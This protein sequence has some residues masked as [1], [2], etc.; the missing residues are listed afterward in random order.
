[1]PRQ[2]PVDWDDLGTALTT[3]PAE[4]SCYLDTRTG[5]VLMVPVDRLDGEDDWPSD[6]EIDAGLDAGHLIAIEP[7]GASVEYGWM[8]EF[9]SRPSAGARVVAVQSLRGQDGRPVNS[10]RAT[11]APGPRLPA[12]ATGRIVRARREAISARP[13]AP[14]SLL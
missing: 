9:T 12:R 6:E 5:Q 11:A 10:C 3:N 4:R 7:L 8:A 1:M 13:G 14:G 2:I